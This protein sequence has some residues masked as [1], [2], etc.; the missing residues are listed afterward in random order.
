MYDSSTSSG[1]SGTLQFTMIHTYLLLTT[2][3]AILSLLYL[4][5]AFLFCWCV[6]KTSV[7]VLGASQPDQI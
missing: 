7:G 2:V 4:S 3:L 6:R 5:T 1:G